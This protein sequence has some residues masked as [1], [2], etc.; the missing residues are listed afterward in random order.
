MRKSNK[1][2][3]TKVEVKPEEQAKEKKKIANHSS[4]IRGKFFETFGNKVADWLRDDV[5]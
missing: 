4:K 3:E 5:E 1:T 2:F